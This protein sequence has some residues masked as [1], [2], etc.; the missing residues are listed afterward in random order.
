MKI[1]LLIFVLILTIGASASQLFAQSLFSGLILSERKDGLMVVD[2]QKGSPVYNAGLKEGDLVVELE[3]KKISKLDEYVRISRTIKKEKVEAYLTIL[4]EGSL[5]EAVIKM[6]SI[7]VYK[8]WK[9]KVAKPGVTPRE[10]N[11]KPFDYWYNKG[12]RALKASERGSTFHLK[13]RH[14]NESITYLYYGLHYKP[15]SIDTAILIAESYQVLGKLYLNKN[16]KEDSVRKY[17][18]S[19][20]LFA[21]CFEKTKKDEYLKIILSNLQ[22]IEKELVR[23]NPAPTTSS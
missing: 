21:R 5:Y 16:M 8:S 2:V 14:Y 17:R 15:D 22:E 9:E 19:L 4:R 1:H 6:Y 18:N 12:K 23:I 13:E 20:R 10:A 7:P 3:G 11:G